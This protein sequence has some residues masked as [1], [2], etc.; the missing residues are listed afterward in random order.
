M[1]SIPKNLEEELGG[2]RE[3]TRRCMVVQD[4]IRAGMASYSREFEIPQSVDEV[5]EY[6]VKSFAMTMRIADL[7]T[8]FPGFPEDTTR[9]FGL[10]SLSLFRH[11]LAPRLLRLAAE[12]DPT[13]AVNWLHKLIS[14]QSADIRYVAEIY[15]LETPRRYT[16]SNG[17]SLMPLAELPSSDMSDDIRLQYEAMHFMPVASA[18]PKSIGVIREFAS[19]PASGHPDHQTDVLHRGQLT[20]TIDAFALVDGAAPVV[21]GYWVEFV[22]A[23][24]AR[25]R[26]GRGC[27]VF[28]PTRVRWIFS[29]RSR[30]MLTLYLGLKGTCNWHRI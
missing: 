6:R 16:L 4:A 1:S 21:G 27:G 5:N 7:V 30:L 19:I 8:Q 12:Q 9:Y 24:L 11:G 2:F 13:T 22:D 17:F 28:R 29:S 18:P 26:K 20:R 15:G 25:A 23:D 10:C 14:T 3:D